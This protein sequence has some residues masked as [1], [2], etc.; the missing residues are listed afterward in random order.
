MTS[1][2]APS[3]TVRRPWKRWLIGVT[4]MV[5]L[6]AVLP[7]AVSSIDDQ[8]ALNSAPIC[9]TGHVNRECRQLVPVTVTSVRLIKGRDPSAIIRTTELGE[10]ELVDNGGNIPD[11]LR[12]GAPLSVEVW[13]GVAV[14]VDVD[15]ES[16]D[17]LC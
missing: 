15:G 4:A 14:R 17:T 7:F 2:V 6:T 13:R 5:G 11:R 12:A 8:H 1:I 10:I 3:R 16:D 9:P